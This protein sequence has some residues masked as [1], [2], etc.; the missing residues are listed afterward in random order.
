MLEVLRFWPLSPNQ[1]ASIPEITH[2]TVILT[3]ELFLILN[4]LTPLAPL[5]DYLSDDLWVVACTHM[6]SK[7]PR[8][9]L[10]LRISILGIQNL[11]K[12][13]KKLIVDL[14]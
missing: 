13:L 14:V 11:I 4:N 1:V 12:F 7:D 9:S 6:E 10:G 2:V 5:N 3:K 8:T